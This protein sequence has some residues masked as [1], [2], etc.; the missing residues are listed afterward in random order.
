MKLQGSALRLTIFV[1]EFDKWHHKPL[2]TRPVHDDRH[3]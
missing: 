1:G 3:R 2:Y